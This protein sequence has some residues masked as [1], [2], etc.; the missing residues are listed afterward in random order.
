MSTT[1]EMKPNF[2]EDVLPNPKA[3]F[4]T[5][6]ED[7]LMKKKKVESPDGLGDKLEGTA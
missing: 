7:D 6:E 1:R 5:T 4:L 2:R 3:L